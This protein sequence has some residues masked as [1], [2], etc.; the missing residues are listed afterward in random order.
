MAQAQRL[1]TPL[2][3]AKYVRM[4]TEHQQYSIDNQ[5]AVIERYAH[6][7]NMEIVRTYVDCGKSGL[8]IENRPGLRQLIADVESGSPGF[9]AVLVYDVS[10]WGRF[11]DVDESAFYEYRCRRARIALHYCAEQ[12]TNDGSTLAALVKTLKRTMAAE[13]SR[14]LSARVFAGQCRLTELGF[15]QGG[16]A[17]Y[18]LRRLLVDQDG[19]PKCVLQRGEYKSIATDRVVL[20]P[21]PRE[22]IQVV[23]EIFHRYVEERQSAEV[24]ASMLN[25]RGARGEDGR[26]WTRQI[27]HRILTNPKYIGANVTNRQSGKLRNRRV[28]NPP[29]MWVRRD[30]AFEAIID[31]GIYEKAV[32]IAKARYAHRTD[33][34]L[35]D[36]L[37]GLVKAHGWVSGP[38][39]KAS[40]DIP[41]P[42]V[43]S[44]RFGGLAEAY[45]RIGYKPYRSLAWVDR[46][47][48]S[49][50]LRREFTGSVMDTLKGFGA[51]VEKETRG[52]LM[53]ILTINRRLR[54]R[55][56]IARCHTP[57]QANTWRFHVRSPLEPDVTIAARLAPGNRSILDYFCIPPI[58]G[59]D[60][61]TMSDR[62]E[63]AHDMQQFDDLNFLREFAQ[64][65]RD[66]RARKTG[67][68]AATGN[69]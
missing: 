2:L 32:A 11:Q 34:E 42:R 17:G 20:I 55:L 9:T 39:I 59:Q 66:P 46:D 44:V 8:M 7:H 21:G 45:R 63:L 4:S 54:M 3:V 51:L 68:R 13:Y 43:F 52:H 64:W 36:M 28:N 23:K 60:Y 67:R 31:V 16:T 22:E 38:L 26:R 27:V 33:E 15:R 69:Q 65:G 18:G 58:K 37:R 62:G 41:C 29:E 47:K 19:K 57:R 49:L 10:R 25:E 53:T 6:D 24:I 48:T 40:R 35:L 50:P 12:F 5:T 1:Q 14:D 30:G 56:S 61:V